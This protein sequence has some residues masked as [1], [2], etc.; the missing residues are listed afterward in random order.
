MR[1][2]FIS[3]DAD[4][5]HMVNLLRHQAKDGRFPFEFKD[6]SVKEPFESRWK[7]EV[8]NLI[9]MS[10]AVIVAIGLNTHESPAVN[11]EIE[12]AHRQGKMVIGVL[13]HRDLDLYAPPAMSSTDPIVFWD[14]YEIA[15]LLEDES[16]EG[17]W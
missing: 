5:E 13:L 14:T 11:W 10:S 12:E 8:R 7:S 16:D 9:S 1:N 17:F 15:G 6:Y 3:F 2:V 4:D